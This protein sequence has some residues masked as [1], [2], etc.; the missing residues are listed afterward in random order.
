MVGLHNELIEKE[1]E[2]LAL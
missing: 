1:K 2:I